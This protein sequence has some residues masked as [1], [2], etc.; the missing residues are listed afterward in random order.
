MQ[1]GELGELNRNNLETNLTKLHNGHL[2]D[3]GVAVVEVQPSRGGSNKTEPNDAW[4][5]PGFVTFYAIKMGFGIH[6]SSIV[7]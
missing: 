6:R 1:Q 4:Y 7:G 5:R 3:R 2:G